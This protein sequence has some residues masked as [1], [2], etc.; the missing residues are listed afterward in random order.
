MLGQRVM[1][2]NV[3]SAVWEGEVDDGEEEAMV[4]TGVPCDIDRVEE[5]LQVAPVLRRLD[6][7][8]WPD[9]W[10]VVSDFL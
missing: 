10:V 7:S 2:R 9:R 3:G 6:G 8:E 4:T 5:S 1:R